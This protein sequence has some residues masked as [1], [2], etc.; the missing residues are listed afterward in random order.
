MATISNV[1]AG[2]LTIKIQRHVSWPPLGFELYETDDGPAIDLTTL[3][4]IRMSVVDVAGTEL[5][6][7]KIGQGFEIINNDLTGQPTILKM[8]VAYIADA[9]A[10][11]WYRH[12][13]LVVAGG[14]PVAY[15]IRGFLIV[16]QNFTS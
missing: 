2:D 14:L 15:P 7:L 6:Q 13:M 4:D 1:I 9:L 8:D 5:L 11:G 3:D 12:D 10:A 16:E